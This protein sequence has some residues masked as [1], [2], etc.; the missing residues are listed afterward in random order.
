MRADFFST[1]MLLLVTIACFLLLTV[2]AAGTIAAFDPPAVFPASTRQALAEKSRQINPPD[3]ER[4]QYTAA[5]WSNRAGTVLTPQHLPDDKTPSD[6]A[7]Y[8]A[9]RPFYWNSIDV[10]CRCTIIELPPS[11]KGG[12][13]GKPDLWIHSPVGLDGPLQK[14]LSELGNV[15]YVI[16]PNYE[17]VKFAPQWAQA[18]PDCEMWGCPGLSER[19]ESIEWKGEI[20]SGYRPKGWKGGVSRTFQHEELTWDT[21]IIQPLHIDI[22]LNPFTG[23][24]FFN[25]VVYFH[26]P[27]E[28]LIMTDLFWNYPAADGVPNSQLGRD[29]SWELAPPL[30]ERVPL[31]SS[32]WKFGM[33]RVYYPFFNGFMVTDRGEYNAIA[34]H[35]VNEW[36]AEMVI[37]AHGDILRGKDFV[38]NVLTK[39]FQL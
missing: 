13:K 4:G 19:L 31:G 1:I 20:P 38:R 18:Y 29:D 25:E 2:E 15:K 9:D 35:I 17:H 10:G 11:S 16:S 8:T 21:D 5:G 27:S 7:L 22:E 14:A 3:A 30:G 34:D 6:G 28:T 32:L 24:P 26:A 36:G 33:D 39:H 23:K 37:P 12:K